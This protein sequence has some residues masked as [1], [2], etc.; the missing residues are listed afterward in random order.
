[1]IL[2][3][4]GRHGDDVFRSFNVDFSKPARSFSQSV[5]FRTRIRSGGVIDRRDGAC[6]L[7]G[8]LEI[9]DWHRAW[10][11]GFSKIS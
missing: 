6:D 7:Q 8:E 5:F 10:K 2:R 9:W 11:V 1:M 3:S 4:I